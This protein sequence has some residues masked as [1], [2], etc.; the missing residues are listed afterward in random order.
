MGSH[1]VQ[2]T[3]ELVLRRNTGE[4]EFHQAV[5]EVFDSLALIQKRH[6]EYAAAAILERLTE[7]ERQIIF[8]VPWVD[9]HGNVQVNRG[10]RVEF[11]SVLGAIQRRIAFSREREL[12]HHQVSRFRTNF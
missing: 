5:Q 9:D 11:N 6:P 1:T 12:K 2:E 8:R 7:P 10:F 4:L 3:F